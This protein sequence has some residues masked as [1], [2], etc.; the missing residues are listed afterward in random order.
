M[1][2]LAYPLDRVGQFLGAPGFWKY[3]RNA[4]RGG[5]FVVEALMRAAAQDDWDIRAEP[6]EFVSEHNACHARHSGVGDDEV[7]TSR[8]RPKRLEGRVAIGTANRFV[9]Q[10]FQLCAP[11]LH[12]HSFIVHHQDAT[13]LME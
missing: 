10:T 13:L 2:G 5:A 4:W 1:A 7:K 11:E 8:C 3:G 12:Q 6:V 9:P